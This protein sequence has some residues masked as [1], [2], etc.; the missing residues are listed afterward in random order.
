MDEALDTVEQLL[1]KYGHTYQA[2]LAMVAQEQ[3]SRSPEQACRSLN[4][5]EW[6]GGR[7][8]VAAADLAVEGGFSAEARED[9]K[10]LRLALIQVYATMLVYGQRHE[11]A[12]IVIA[13]FK[14]WLTSHV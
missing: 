10:R 1:R 5:D 9:G 6:W 7:E 12:E 13:Q 2:N 11:Q 4:D 14:K 8:S 3:F